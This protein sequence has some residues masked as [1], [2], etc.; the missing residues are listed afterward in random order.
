MPDIGLN[1]RKIR[2]LRGLTQEYVAEQLGF[3]SP[4]SY[5]KLETGEQSPTLSQLEKIAEVFDCDVEYLRK[6][7]PESFSMQKDIPIQFAD[8]REDRLEKIIEQQNSK[9]DALLHQFEKLGALAKEIL[10]R[11]G[12]GA[13]MRSKLKSC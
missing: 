6:F 13:K 7:D 2:K 4:K 11:A 10:N 3:K 5:R 9:I 8:A 1:I 12:G